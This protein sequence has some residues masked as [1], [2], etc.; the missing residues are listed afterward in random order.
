MNQLLNTPNPALTP[1]PE[2]GE[3]G[4]GEMGRGMT[5]I[6]NIFIPSL[7]IVNF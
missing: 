3:D 6:G 5:R 2:K 7:R 4:G 1:G